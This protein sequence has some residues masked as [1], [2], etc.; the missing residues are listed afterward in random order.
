MISLTETAFYAR[1]TINW[2]ILG[3]I[4][5]I[6]L[7]IVWSL[8]VFFLIILFPPQPPPPNHRF[9]K[10]P[11]LVF[12]IQA[13]P[14]AQL[15][16]H[17]ETIEGAVPK[18]SGS[19]TVYFMPKAAPNLL[20]LTN[21]Q[22]FAQKLQFN[23]TP[24]Q[25]SKNI[26]RFNDTEFP[27]R[28]LRFDIVTSNFIIRYGFEQDFS[29]FSQKNLPSQE[30][31]IQETLNLLDSNLRFHEDLDKSSPSVSYLRL[32]GNSLVPTT[33]LSQSDAVRVDIF[34]KSIGTMPVVTPTN[35]EAAISI[36]FTGS[37]IMKKHIIQF[38]Y[39]YWP[40]DYQMSAT[41]E[42][43]TSDE[44]WR[45]LNDGRGYIAK[46]PINSSSV[47]VRNVY[48]AYYDSFESQTYL[49]PIFVFEGDGGFVGYVP[50]IDPMWVE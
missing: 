18:A 8:T 33:S 20:A 5:Y 30:I 28:R 43:K 27:L 13:S 19:A 6:I 7:R 42:L 40:V 23:P 11:Q 25:E 45:E 2:V 50:A 17:L 4:A 9:G 12:P 34:R 24:I 10:L 14:S 39:T 16:Y 21:T 32:S 37:T 36:I 47:V 46:Y 3:V 26:Y 48:L 35:T 49:Q 1:R 29:V 44:A 31:I 22:E 38:A 41:Y 15:S